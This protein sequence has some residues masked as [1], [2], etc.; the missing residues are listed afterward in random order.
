MQKEKDLKT[1]FAD[2]IKAAAKKHES[3]NWDTSYC[4]TDGTMQHTFAAGVCV[5]TNLEFRTVATYRGTE[6]IDSFSLDDISSLDAY[7]EFLVRTAQQ[8]KELND[9]RASVE[10]EP[11]LDLEDFSKKFFGIK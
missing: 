1:D 6:K 11:S 10:S 4:S 9:Q 5:I 8:A 3:L 2:I 7:T